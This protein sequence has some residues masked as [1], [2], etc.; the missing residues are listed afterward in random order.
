MTDLFD[1]WSNGSSSSSSRELGVYLRVTRIRLGL[2]LRD[3]Q[4]LT[5]VLARD[6]GNSEYQISASWLSRVEKNNRALTTNKLAG[7][8][9]VYDLKPDQVLRIK[10]TTSCLM[11][12]KGLQKPS[13]RPFRKRKHLSSG[14]ANNL[15]RDLIDISLPEETT[16][17][18][19]E[20]TIRIGR[21]LR[22]VIG[23]KD[24]TLE[25]MILAGS[26]VFIDKSRKSVVSRNNWTTEFD[27]PIYFLCTRDKYFCGFC[28][29]DRKSEWLTLVPHLLSP[30]S[31]ERRWKYRRDVEVIG[32]VAA[33][34]TA[35][36]TAP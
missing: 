2:S 15:S 3:V 4:A 32:T 36:A 24:R 13:Y 10:T 12:A 5:R 25:P 30:E 18:Q 27:R 16:I 14:S 21:Y 8:A 6:S 1:P 33:I 20:P 26:I 35:R 9:A 23:S 7:L 11:P 17:L 31:N 28:E 22:A 34:L 19:A 29:L